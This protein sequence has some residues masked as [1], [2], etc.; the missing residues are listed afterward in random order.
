MRNWL[1]KLLGGKPAGQEKGEHGER[2]AALEGE[3]QSL[4]LDLQEQTA[5]V[6]RLK[7]E[8]E[9]E[10]TGT[11]VAD[12]VHAQVERLL[13]DAGAPVAQLHTQAHLLEQGRPVPARDVMA[14][15][16]RLVRVLED[17]GLTPES[18]VGARV[19][20]DPDRH[21]PLSA[22]TAIRPGRPVVVR[23]VGM[24][25]QGKLLRKAGVEPAGVEE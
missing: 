23:F 11:K 3:V 22:A 2:V 12:Q 5:L 20:F 15:A 16:R 6:G 24:R 14:V 18:S 4:R 9:R 13:A 21:E 25:Y 8:L 19:P 10:R 1:I 7:Q 17:H